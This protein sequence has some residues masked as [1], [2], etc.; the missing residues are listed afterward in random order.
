[1]PC[2]ASGYVAV[3]AAA[4]GLAEVA[5]DVGVLVVQ[6]VMWCGEKIQENYVDA[7]NRWTEQTENARR[8]NLSKVSDLPD[9][10]SLQLERAAASSANLV[11][12]ASASTSPPLSLDDGTEREIA[13]ALAQARNVLDT[14]QDVV[15]I[16]AENERELWVQRVKAELAACRGIL[17]ATQITAAEAALRGTVPQLQQALTSLQQ[18][19]QA[20]TDTQLLRQH[21]ERQVTT[22]IQ[23]ATSQLQ[24]LT[25]LLRDSGKQQVYGQQLQDI[26][27]RL[28]QAKTKLSSPSQALSLVTGIQNDIQA[29]TRT[30]SKEMLR[31][32]ETTRQEI[33]TLQGMLD[34][35]T[36]M[37]KEATKLKLLDDAQT[38]LFTQRITSAQQEALALLQ[39]RATNLQRR[40]H[41]L[42]ERINTLKEE[43]FRITKD[44]QQARIAHTIATTLSEQGFDSFNGGTP[45]VQ[46][47]GNNLR[48][49]TIRTQT[50][51]DGK[52]DD[53][54]VTFDV[55]REGEI[56][57]DCSGYVGNASQVDIERIFNA[58][59][60]KGIF[61]LDS[62]T[63]EELQQIPVQQIT[64]ATL[65]QQRFTPGSEQH[66]AQSE[67]AQQL[68]QVLKELHYTDIHQSAVGGYIDLEAFNG[69]AGYHIVL[70]PNGHVQV[71]K[72]QQ[73][74]SSDE[75]DP[76]VAE[77]QRMHKTDEIAA[78]RQ[79][80]QKIRNAL[81]RPVK[82]RKRQMLSQ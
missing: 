78:T 57:Y 46:I 10:I 67:I 36:T 81:H 70:P 17:P 68:L 18:A 2:R 15:R 39:T 56:T 25:V 45:S 28:E 9:F 40:L 33:V 51:S 59:R 12:N 64:P 23:S 50:N 44:G 79:E 35:L 34:S 74:I 47:Y 6:G 16:R 24:A 52:R 82:Q 75:K 3:E 5:V 54:V 11:L 8:E 71:F 41:L 32:W 1:M 7:C 13:A 42:T 20:A 14:G 53:K 55:S 62:R 77:A 73:D 63:V 66:K 65:R 76:I 4:A 38:K 80:Q 72:D 37:T 43:V 22:A 27:T 26:S 58:L 49:S 31:A 69:T 60:V 21:Q 29:L 48:V 61:I 30:I 19:V